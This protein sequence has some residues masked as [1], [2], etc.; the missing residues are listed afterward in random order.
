MIFSGYSANIWQANYAGLVY[1]NNQLG[2][3]SAASG[4]VPSLPT[5]A[6]EAQGM[7]ASLRNGAEA[8]NAYALNQAWAAQASSLQ[9]VQALPLILD[10]ATISIFDARVTTYLTANAGLA[11]IIPQAPYESVGVIDNAEP[12]VPS[13]GLLDFFSTFS[14]ETA[15]SGLTSANLVTNA[16]AVATAMMTVANAIQVYQ[17]SNITQLYDVVYREYLCAVSAANLLASMTSGPFASDITTVNTWNQVVALPSMLM[18]GDAINGACFTEQLQQQA[19]LRYAQLK[20]ADSVALLLLSLRQPLT[21]KINLTTL[22]VNESLI[23]VAARAL[24][25][26]ELWPEIATLNGLEPPYVG[27][28]SSQG[29]AGWGSQLILPAPGTN[30]S[31]I[32]TL[33]SYNANYLGID[34]YI[35][36]INGSMPPWAGDFQTIGGVSNLRISLGRRIQTTQG[37]LIYHPQFGSRIPPEVGKIQSNV[38]AGHINAYGESALQ[39]DPRVASVTSAQTQILPNGLVQFISTVQPGGFA[40]QGV[41]INETIS[42]LA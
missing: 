15:P 9:S 18:C 26:F 36:P 17:G 16:Y 19:V 24:N 38:T 8:I 22:R 34:I 14:Y 13:A 35:G 37:T 20:S 27:A 40:S 12:I 5:I 28:T 30:I 1:F 6:A 3:L 2:A 42:P 39:S 7:Y 11:G 21:S 10:S 31:S 29:I 33:P 25:N 23:D 41:T 4:V 32:G